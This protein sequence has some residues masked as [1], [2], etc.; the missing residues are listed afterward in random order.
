MLTG[1][2]RGQEGLLNLLTAEVS[3]HIVS[4]KEERKLGEEAQFDVRFPA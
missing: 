3:S 4:E 1:K 2:V